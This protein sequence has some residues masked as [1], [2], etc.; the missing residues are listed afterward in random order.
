M[1]ENILRE[2]LIPIK[3]TTRL[4]VGDPWYAPMQDNRNIVFNS[5]ISA[6]PLGLLRLREVEGVYEDLGMPYNDYVI[7]IWQASS[8]EKLRVY[9]E[10]KYYKNTL[11]KEMDLGCDTACFEIGTK[12]ASDQFKTGAD[13]YFGHIKQ[14]KQYYGMHLELSLCGDMFEYDELKN[15]LLKVFPEDKKNK[16]LLLAAR[17]VA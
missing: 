17:S 11:K 13:G 5:S 16:N 12:Y 7:D 10:G 14:Y 1:N 8:S 9:L 3:G 4:W 15:R 2:E 6:A